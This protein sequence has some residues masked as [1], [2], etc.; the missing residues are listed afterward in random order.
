MLFLLLMCPDDTIR[1]KRNWM[2]SQNDR[3]QGS[4][5]RCIDKDL[6]KNNSKIR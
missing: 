1:I 4:K 3:E 5:K 6:K 2:L